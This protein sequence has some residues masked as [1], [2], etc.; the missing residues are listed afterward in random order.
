MLRR[1]SL[2]LPSI[3]TGEKDLHI[4][5]CLNDGIIFIPAP[6]SFSFQRDFPR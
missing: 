4:D 1:G 5:A 6:F 2:Q 3:R